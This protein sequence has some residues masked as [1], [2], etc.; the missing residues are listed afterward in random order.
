MSP[1]VFAGLVPHPPLLV[2]GVGDELKAEAAETDAAY[3]QLALRLTEHAPA[4]VVII[5]PHG[6]IFA[7]VY[8]VLAWPRLKGDF[9]PFGSTVSMAWDNDC[10]YV[11]QA[12]QLATAQHL[13]L[14]SIS[15]RQLNA[16]RQS[17][18]LDH[19]TL[20]PLYYLKKAGWQ[21]RVVCIRIG[22]ISPDQCFRIGKVLAQA[23]DNKSVALLAS[24]DLS[25]CLSDN[26]PSP[27][28]PA[29]REFDQIIVSALKEGNFQQ[30]FNLPPE[31]RQRA[32][33]C[34]WRPL[35]TL[36]GA[37]D[38][39]SV[40]TAVL[41][42]QGPFGVGYLVAT[43][44]LDPAGK[45][46]GL[47]PPVPRPRDKT[48]QTKLARQAIAHYLATG[49]TLK[50]DLDLGQPA[51]VFVSL[52]ADDQL[53]GCI[54]TVEPVQHS[55]AKEIVV[56]AI[57]AATKDPRFEPVLP[58]ELEPLKITVDILSP[59]KPAVFAELAP[60][61]KGLVVEWQ[62]RRGLLLPALPG[63]DEPEQQLAI[64][65][66]KAGIPLSRREDLRL[67]TFTVERYD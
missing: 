21:G 7:D 19:G 4:T 22:G 18:N 13:P 66:K 2:E 32:A 60:D 1:L 11:A 46:S 35:V 61:S 59:C 12:C 30:I 29:G 64:A 62:G 65:M 49:E 58:S 57:D 36:L 45:S 42:Y 52:K 41:N 37:L 14:V 6:P 51:G 20:L 67:Y 53:R 48:P 55:L 28:N 34:G 47:A 27:Y 31:L 33:E 16:H 54:G 39:Y 50:T 3:Q 38:G 40:T 10:S 25:H 56:N 44:E 5:S 15:Q 23:A 8:T 24:G 63:I 17:V 26:G 43:M 9:T